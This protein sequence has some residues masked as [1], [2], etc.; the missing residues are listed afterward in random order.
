[1]GLFPVYASRLGADEA[2]S[3][4]YMATVFTAIVGGT[5]AAGWLSDRFQKRKW[6]MVIAG[7]GGAV[8]FFLA[9][10]VTQLW[11]L[12]ILIDIESFFA[13]IVIATISILT[14]LFA[15][16][17]QRGRVFGTLAI[18][19][20]L[21]SVLGSLGIGPIADRWGYSALFVASGLCWV[22]LAL[23]ALLIED[24]W[25]PPAASNPHPNMPALTAVPKLSGAFY[26]LLVSNVLVWASIILAN[27][28]RPIQMD[29]LGFDA[30]AIAGAVALG[31]IVSLPFPYIAGW[32]SDR[33][34]RYRLISLCFLASA[35][36]LA[37]LAAS[38]VLWHFWVVCILAAGVGIS[39]GVASALVTDLVPQEALGVALARFNATN[40]IG[41]IIG[42]AGAGYAIQYFGIATTYIIGAAF[43]LISIVLLMQVQRVRKLAPA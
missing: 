30:A 14:G 26:L 2:S 43:T 37:I 35:V 41:S 3:G 39:T 40:W 31:G 13:G 9:S 27:L 4:N 18:T 24:K 8:A 20:G 7:I 33:I 17:A 11:Q 6:Q 23:T 36:S 21:G 22:V 28:G 1:M 12:M 42:F 25:V 16:K 19:L 10:Q 32:L 5:V 29:R 38:T 34:G 15:E